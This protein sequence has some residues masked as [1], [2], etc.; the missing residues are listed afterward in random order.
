MN[1]SVSEE[2]LLVEYREGGI[3]VVT[4]NAPKL[5]LLDFDM[6]LGLRQTFLK[7]GRNLDLRVIILTGAGEKAFCAGMDT[8]STGDYAPGVN[9][10]WGESIMNTIENCPVPVIAALHGYCL[11][12]GLEM[13]LACDIRIAAENTVFRFPEAGIGLTPAWGGTSRLPWLIGEGNAKMMFYTGYDFTAQEALQMGLVQKC[14]PMEQLMDACMELAQRIATRAPRSL[15]A[16]KKI[17]HTSRQ[18]ILGASLL[19]EQEQT[20]ICINSE[21]TREGMA[22]MREK[23]QPIFKNK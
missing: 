16:I 14:V 10:A 22:A 23:R 5:N 7:L 20:F 21:D 18:P 6:L 8:K 13:S 15:A 19:E 12:G 9:T 3:A 1:T 4:M 11:G 2:K 17:I